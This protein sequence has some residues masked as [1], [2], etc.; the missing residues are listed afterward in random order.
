V[1]HQWLVVK[2]EECG[3]NFQIMGTTSQPILHNY[4][5]G[6][7]STLAA[8]SYYFFTITK[9]YYNKFILIVHAI[10]LYWLFI[11]MTRSHKVHS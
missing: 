6:R 4:S 1:W 8:D 9:F 10:S 11:V 5:H 7:P 3:E 2:L